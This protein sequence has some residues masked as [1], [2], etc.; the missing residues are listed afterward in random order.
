MLYVEDF[1]AAKELDEIKLKYKE[2]KLKNELIQNK[3]SKSE[4]KLLFSLVI[5]V[6]GIGIIFLVIRN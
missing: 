6:M 1:K 4:L 3:L 5:I 2:E